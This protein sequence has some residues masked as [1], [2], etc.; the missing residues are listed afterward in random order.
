MGDFYQSSKLI[1]RINWD[2]IMQM[3]RCAGGHDKQMCGLLKNVLVIGHWNEGDYQGT[4][5]TCVMLLDTGETVIYNDY[6]GSCS[7]CDAWEDASD[8]DVVRMCKQLAA[9]AYIFT[10]VYDCI[11]FLKEVAAADDDG[12]SCACEYPEHYDWV[13]GV[14]RGL[15]VEIEKGGCALEN[16][17]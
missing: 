15:L 8:E 16:N 12:R 10:N 5:A 4:V 6:Y 9:G 2:N 13:G 11:S 1:G 14:A 17:T 3:D 7:G